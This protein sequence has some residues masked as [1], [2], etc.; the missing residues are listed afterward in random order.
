[1]KHL[2]RA[3]AVALLMVIS[4][5]VT[6]YITQMRSRPDLAPWHTA[7]L[8]AEYNAATARGIQDLDA[9]RKLEDGLFRQLNDQVYRQTQTDPQL[10]WNRF[11]PASWS[12]PD[13]FSVNWNRTFE[14]TADR[15]TAGFL[16][17]HGLSDSPYSMRA[18]AQRL[19][20]EG[21]LVVGL[22]LPGH[23]TAP[24]GLTHVDWHDWR[25]AV[26][27]AARHLAA[28]LGPDRPLY[29]VGYSNG[30]ALALEYTLSVIE[31]EDL[32]RTAGLLLL[33][34]AVAVSPVAVLARWQL[35]LSRLPGLEKLAWLSIQPEYDPYKYNSF[36]V[37]AGFQIYRL[38][39]AVAQRLKKLDS[40]NGVPGFPPVLVFQSVLDATIPPQAVVD[41]LLSRLAPN[42]H[43]LVLF[44]VN[45]K[46]ETAALFTADP[47]GEI[48][49][50]FARPLPFDLTLVTNRTPESTALAA[51]HKPALQA[52]FSETRLGLAWPRGIYSLSHVAIP[53]PPDDPI[54]GL[55]DQEDEDKGL[56][57]GNVELRGERAALQIP[58]GNLMRLRYNPF[59]GYME[60][61]I[62]E[63]YVAKDD[64]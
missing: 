27:L 63:R 7:A 40:G 9:Y 26:R 19:H 33:S 11:Q 58:I 42:N 61:Q 62:L 2:M 28:K 4:A 43:R 23:G 35:W 47:Q 56:T 16:M 44:G 6:F 32:P 39:N 24:A 29:L 53:F 30:A 36:P 8:Q 22:R 15:P 37:N 38:T 1:M 14:L 57:L 59:F 18:L 64:R 31:G 3:F 45:R 10:R 17:L 21:A 52:V 13:R 54:Y 12:N 48:D 49:A 5:G 50:L 25:G 60:Q 51:R 34:P 46:A 20:R 41:A 55:G